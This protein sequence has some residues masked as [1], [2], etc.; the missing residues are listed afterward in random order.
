M[1]SEVMQR[2][3]SL[4]DAEI[5][6][7]ELLMSVAP[8]RLISIGGSL[9]VCLLRNRE[10][11]YDIDCVLDPNLAAVKEYADEFKAAVS[12]VARSGGFGQ[13][14]LNRQLETFIA[15]D[16]RGALFLESVDQGITVYSGPNLTVFAGRLDW[17]LERKL[18]RVSHARDRRGSKDV[19]IPDAA[20]LIKYMVSRTNKPLSFDFAR[21]LNYNGFDLKPTDEAL[22]AV[23][24]HYG[25]TYGA[26]GLFKY[27]DL[28]KEWVWC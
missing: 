11:S 19:D 22:R 21:S 27:Q 13:D 16:R 9:A 1:T 7:S 2:A 4:L 5:S 24:R 17:A 26:V 10:S 12:K 6:N 18:R 25:E 28:N 14:W 3:L 15:R 8:I 20:A 23:A